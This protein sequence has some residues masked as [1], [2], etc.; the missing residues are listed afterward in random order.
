MRNRLF[1]IVL[2]TLLGFSAAYGQQPLRGEQV[3]HLTTD[4]NNPR[5]SEGSFIT[6]KDGRIL[7]IYSRFEGSS[8]DHAPAKLM[9]RFSSDNGKTWTRED[10][11]IIDRE[12]DMNVMSASLLR[13]QNGE[14][15]LVYLQKNSLDD[16]IPKIR[17]SRDE[18][19][20]WD[21]PIS[22][23]TD[24]SG[25]FVVNNDRIIQLSN[26]R[27][28][29]PTSLHKTKDSP[30][31]NSG[32]LRCYFSDDQGMTWQS[33]QRVPAHDTLI[34]QEPGVVELSDGRLMM[35]IRAGGGR[36]YQSYSSD[37]GNTWS[38]AMPSG[39]RSPISPAS[40]KR[41][42]GTDHLLAVTNNNGEK[43][44][45]YHKSKRTPLTMHLSRDHGRSWQ[46]IT[47][48]ETNPNETYAYT[49][50]HFHNDYVLMGYYVKPD[51]DPGYSIKLKRYRIK[52]IYETEKRLPVLLVANKH[53]NTLSWVDPVGFDVFKT[54]EVGP[55]PHEIII[56]P[57]QKF[58]YL[59]NYAPPGNTIS[60]IDLYARKHIK[61]INTGTVGRI[62]GTAMAPDGRHAY[63]TAGQSGQIVEIN[64]KSNEITRTIPTHGKISHMVYVS[65]DGRYL[66]TSNIVSENISLIE[67]KSGK[68]I[69]QIPAGKGVE[70]MAFTPD[71]K[72]LWALN[73]TGGS[74][75]IINTKTWEPEE[76][77][78]CEGMPVRIKFTADGATALIANW[79]KNGTL[80]ILDTRSKKEIKRIPVGDYA[81]GIEISPDGRY[82][83]V[84]CEDAQKTE[85][86]PDGTETIDGH[87]SASDGIHVIDLKSLKVIDIIK[88]GLGPDPMMLWYPGLKLK[89]P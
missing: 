36:Q 68:L 81:I 65:P 31:S 9:G 57:D 61:Q 80:T 35:I 11:L 6:L 4:A 14:I 79:V 86:L 12:G 43:G 33:G 64:T 34:T 59:S 7:F 8:S 17:K 87:K 21:K 78:L 71:G 38:Y 53:S 28:V 32:Q 24:R 73:Q 15:A 63:F 26:G 2:F 42:P 16:C 30:Y 55:N 5:N 51:D 77:F 72:K 10:Q 66:L 70:G 76:T 48:I 47:D 18:G 50:I 13:L 54:I 41:I 62:H 22:I 39:L 58:A 49:A 89:R 1:S 27:L 37:G 44:P 74:I 45:G 69:Q 20:S 67:R 3:L 60:V 29:V 85:M 88:T 52:D 40:V 82:A 46:T 19:K 25:Y 56:T 83:F 23:I 84:G 75:T